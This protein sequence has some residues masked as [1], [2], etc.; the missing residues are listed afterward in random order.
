MSAVC[1]CV[2][3]CVVRLGVGG[4][5]EEKKKEN[6][7]RRRRRRTESSGRHRRVWSKKK[8]RERICAAAPRWAPLWR[9]SASITFS[10]TAL[11]P[12]LSL[13][14]SC[15]Q[16]INARRTHTTSEGRKFVIEPFVRLSVH[17][18]IL[19]C[20]FSV[21]LLLRICAHVRVYILSPHLLFLSLL[22][23]CVCM[24][25]CIHSYWWSKGCSEVTFAL[26]RSFCIHC[27]FSDTM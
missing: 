6:S 12:S 23:V 26:A 11:S 10:L 4:G 25:A 7:Q 15:Y 17:L 24:C 2:C 1:K 3:P 20:L 8:R 19:C 5:D 18:S 22:C 9:D 21:T 14:L 13:T 27:S 16:S